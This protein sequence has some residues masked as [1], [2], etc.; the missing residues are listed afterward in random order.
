MKKDAIHIKYLITNER[1]IEWGLTVN[2]VGFQHIEPEEVYPPQNHPTRYLFNTDKGRILDEYQLLYITQGQGEFVSAS[3]KSQTISEGKMF[4]LYP[5][6]WHAY[7]PDKSTGWNEYWIGFS[8]K[9]MDKRID[10]NF[11]SKQKPILNVGLQDELVNMF[12]QA[13]VTAKEQ[14]AGFQQFLAGTVDYLLGYAYSYNK[15][16]S[17]EEMRIVKLINK[18]KLIIT[19]NIYTNISPNELASRLNISY[20]WFR[21]IFKQYTGF[22]PMQYINEM[23]IQKS[24]ELLTNSDLSNIEIAD[25]LGFDNPNYFCTLFKKKTKVTP[26]TYRVITQGKNIIIKD[27]IG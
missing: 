24:K 6:E 10:S 16:S 18:S 4:L 14:K 8:G 23:K 22:S 12:L 25:K 5:G 2:T 17:F 9:N 13:I 3:C 15:S 21:K 19:E 11:F 1:D 20:S 27:R 7:K 26:M